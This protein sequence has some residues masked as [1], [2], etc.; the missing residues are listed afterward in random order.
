MVSAEEIAQ[1]PLFASLSAPDR[2]RLAHASADVRL[3][4][5][6]FAVH[7]GEERALFAVLEGRI[8]AVKVVDGIPSVLGERLP[9]Q[10]F[11]EVPITLGA[12]FPSGFRAAETSRVMQVEARDYYAVAGRAIEGRGARTRA[13]RGP[14]GSRREGTRD[15]RVRARASLGRG[16]VR[17]PALPRSQPDH[18]RMGHARRRRRSPA[19]AVRAARGRGRYTWTGA[20]SC[21]PSRQRVVPAIRLTSNAAPAS[22]AVH[23]P[24]RLK[25]TAVPASPGGERDERGGEGAHCARVGAGLAPC[26]PVAPRPLPG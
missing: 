24:K 20:T 7:E 22:P 5:G 1:I 12:A 8:E 13:H 14:A 3:A 21:A 2:V 9:G 10:I 19:V 16:H 25:R 6:E 15:P 23:I 11:G 18:V 17:S 4:E 26:D